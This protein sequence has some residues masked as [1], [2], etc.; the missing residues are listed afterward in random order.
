MTR[1]DPTSPL[2]GKTGYGGR[3]ALTKPLPPVAARWKKCGPPS[4]SA[5]KSADR[6][7][8]KPIEDKAF[9]GIGRLDVH[10]Y[11][12]YTYRMIDVGQQG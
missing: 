6:V 12:I 11:G 4:A 2:G 1:F 5:D 8:R 9:F 3:R 7:Q 10:R